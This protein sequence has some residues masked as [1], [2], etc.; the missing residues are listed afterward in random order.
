MYISHLREPMWQTVMRS[1]IG[2][3]MYK[4]TNIPVELLNMPFF[5]GKK[6]S[7]LIFVLPLYIIW[8]QTKKVDC[9][10]T[11][12]SASVLRNPPQS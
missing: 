7:R 1:W 5:K 11:T 8:E 6:Y 9:R 4:P 10:I 12:R 2:K 3:N